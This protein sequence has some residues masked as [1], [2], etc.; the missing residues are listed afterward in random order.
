MT[1]LI[2][3]TDLDCKVYIDTELHGIAKIGAEYVIKLERGPYWIVC[4][5]CENYEDRTDF[6]FR[7]NGSDYIEHQEVGLKPIRYKRLISIYDYVGEFQCGFAEVRQ[8]FLSYDED[9]KIVGYI[10]QDGDLIYYYGY[11]EKVLPFGANTICVKKD[12]VWGIFNSFGEYIIEP[13]YDFIIPIES[14]PAIFS[15]DNKYGLLNRNGEIIVPAK[16]QRLYKIDG[17]DLICCYLNE[18][19][20]LFDY[21]G[22]KITPLKYSEI[23]NFTSNGLARVNVGGILEEERDPILRNIEWVC[24]G[25]QY[26]YVDT[27]GKEILPIK[28][29]FAD[30]FENELA[31]VKINYKEG[32]INKTGKE[33]IPIKYSSARRMSDSLICVELDNKWGIV[34]NNGEEIYP[35]IYDYLG[36]FDY[37]LAIVNQNKKYSLIDT[38]NGEIIT[39]RK[40]DHICSI[41]GELA[42][43][44]INGK[45]GF[46]DRAGNEIVPCKY[47][48]VQVLKDG[49][50]LVKLNNETLQINIDNV[51]IKY[52]D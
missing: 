9:G 2:L 52:A 10:N 44:V 41:Y 3:H 34:N 51:K 26:G 32:F 24:N 20:G 27:S 50:I 25:G 7:T 6:D 19:Y 33:I 13:Q 23:N 16:Y 18:R 8:R 42:K 38:N 15:I 1:T 48:D 5:S 35:L 21:D 46:I 22:Y 28:Y 4:V 37:N 11:F 49:V 17:A 30:D 12:G 14:G 43:V 29:D 36:C 47:D 45:C 39:K 31:W 40:Y